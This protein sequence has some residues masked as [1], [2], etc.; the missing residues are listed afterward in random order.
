ME[1]SGPEE[2]YIEFSVPVALY[3]AFSIPKRFVQ[4]S[5]Q[6]LPGEDAHGASP[7]HAHTITLRW[8]YTVLKVPFKYNKKGK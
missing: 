7:L 8:K 2:L 3:T 1:Y 4:L 6:N 5:G